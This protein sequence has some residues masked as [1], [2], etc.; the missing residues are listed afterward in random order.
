MKMSLETQLGSYM[1]KINQK[2]KVVEAWNKDLNKSLYAWERATSVDKIHQTNAVGK[3]G[4]VK[5]ISPSLGYRIEYEQNG[6]PFRAWCPYWTIEAYQEEVVEEG[7]DEV[8]VVYKFRDME[9][10]TRAEA[11]YNQSAIFLAALHMRPY[12]DFMAEVKKN[13]Q[14]IIKH[15]LQINQTK[16]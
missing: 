5:E 2:V 16:I 14:E 8:R 15:I 1:F 4:V 13:S 3:V 10:D 6:T 12:G 7:K 11:E 9:F